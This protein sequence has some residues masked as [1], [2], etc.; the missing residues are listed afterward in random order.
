MRLFWVTGGNITGKTC[1]ST[2]VTYSTYRQ[3]IPD[4]KE[5]KKPIVKG[6]LGFFFFASKYTVS[7]SVVG[8]FG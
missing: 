6:F 3:K 2:Y 4:K 7:V 1:N 8:S 5:A